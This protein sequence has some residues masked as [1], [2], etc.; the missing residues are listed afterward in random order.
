MGD[1]RK[2]LGLNS[3]FFKVEGKWPGRTQGAGTLGY[4]YEVRFPLGVLVDFDN[5]NRPIQA[6]RQD[7]I[8]IAKLAVCRSEDS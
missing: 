2:T 6:D 8:K 7:T 3:R 4:R 5:R 1:L